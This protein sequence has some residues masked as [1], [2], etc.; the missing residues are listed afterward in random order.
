MVGTHVLSHMCIFLECH[1]KNN[2]TLHIQH[3]THKL[4]ARI[5]NIT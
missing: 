5:H 1:R 4:T 2:L 3:L